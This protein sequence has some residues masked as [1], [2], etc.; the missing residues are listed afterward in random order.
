MPVVALNVALDWPDV[1][2]TDDGVVRLELLS[3]MAT[4]VL[5]VVVRF[6]VTVQTAEAEEPNVVGPHDKDDRV[7]A[8]AVE[9]TCTVPPVAVIVTAAPL[10]EAATGE[11]T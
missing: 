9:P 5:L 3:L 6:I 10:L 7:S 8:G 2:V 1:T 4:A 11:V